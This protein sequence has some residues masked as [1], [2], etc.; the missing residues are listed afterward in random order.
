M[1]IFMTGATGY[2]GAVLRDQLI[3]EGH[4]VH[5]IYRPSSNKDINF[6]KPGVKYF[7]GNLLDVFSLRNAMKGCDQAYHVAAYARVWSRDPTLFYDVN[8]VGTRN[9]LN[10]AL[11]LGISKVVVTSTGATLLSSGRKNPADETD[12]KEHFTTEYARTKSL[13]EEETR[14]HNQKGL[15]TVIVNPPRVYGPGLLSESNAATK[16]IKWYT[17]GKWRF[18]PGDGSYIGNYAF[19]NDVATGHRQAMEYGE[20]GEQYILGGKNM[21]FNELFRLVAEVIGKNYKLWPIPIPLIK[22]FAKFEEWKADRM[23]FKPLI[24]PQWVENYMEDSALSSIKAITELNY[25]IT[26]PVKAIS[27]T[28]NWL[29]SLK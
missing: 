29:K 28:V 23:K 27:E 11:E 6:S 21:S 14:K 5:A 1:K 17:E 4:T 20:S 22:N 15:Q 3:E 8:V 24:T 26:P 9:V 2:I 25:T 19:V 16:L 10:L 12:R 13:A 7:E 18:I